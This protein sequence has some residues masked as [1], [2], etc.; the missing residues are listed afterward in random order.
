MSL[1]PDDRVELLEGVIV[2]EPPSNPRGFDWYDEWP[3][4]RHRVGPARGPGEPVAAGR[5]PLDLGM[6]FLAA[7]LLGKQ[8]CPPEAW[9]ALRALYAAE[10]ATSTAR[11]RGSSRRF[12]RAASGIRP[13]SSSSPIT[14]RGSSPS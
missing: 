14:A 11:S 1:S 5:T 12:A 10:V 9:A 8:S 13:S 3:A 7:C 4:R 2:A 6:D